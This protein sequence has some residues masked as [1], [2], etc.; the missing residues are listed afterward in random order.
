ML[1]KTMATG[2]T[3]E[4][5]GYPVDARLLIINA[6]DFGRFQSINDAILRT[7][8]EG[9]VRS[10]TLMVPCQGA[11]YAMQALEENPDLAFGVHLTLIAD[12]P[13]KRWGSVTPKEQV[14]S[15]VDENGE[16][17]NYEQIPKLLELAK[18]DELEIE[19]R[20]Q[21]EHVLAAGL[22]PTHLDFHCLF[23]AG[24]PDIFDMTVELAKEYGLALR[25]GAQAM[26]EKLQSE[27]LPTNDHVFLDSYR[28][29]DVG[30]TARF[31][32][33]LRELPPG[34]S[35]WAAHPGLDTP[36]SREL[37]PEGWTI[38]FA[39]FEFLTSQEAKDT[40]KEEG[41]ILLDYRPLQAFWSRG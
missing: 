8:T 31:V 21:I 9:V 17:Y 27:D 5:L 32:Q 38:R 22:K 12:P 20:A 24:G 2:R 4:L 3:N 23:D 37:D 36:E 28:L 15:L 1:E 13:T 16:F 7:M 25:V 41:I 19:F 30:K 14:P 33:L 11:H 6:D 39:D 34:L 35:E 40:V 18:L 26:A 29:G 10:T